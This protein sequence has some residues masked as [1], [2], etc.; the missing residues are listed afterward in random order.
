MVACYETKR[1]KTV[2]FLHHGKLLK[3]IQKK[4]WKFEDDMKII[5]YFSYVCMINDLMCF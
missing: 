3:E 5:L 2:H 1:M 4:T